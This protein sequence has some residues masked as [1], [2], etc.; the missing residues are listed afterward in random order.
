[1]RRYSCN[2]DKVQNIVNRDFQNRSNLDMVVSNINIFHTDRGNEFKSKIK[3][4][5]LET[6]DI[7]RLLRK[8]GRSYD[9]AVAEPT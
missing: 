6:F 2:K 4:E 3:D 9:N 8:K 1:M 5:V 7:K